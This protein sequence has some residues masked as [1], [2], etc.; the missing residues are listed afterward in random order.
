MAVEPVY[1]L[2]AHP[3]EILALFDEARSVLVDCDPALPRPRVLAFE[4]FESATHMLHGREGCELA[5]EAVT[6]ERQSDD[7]VTLADALACS[8]PASKGRPTSPEAGARR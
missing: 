2:H 3:N 5:E 6:L 7:P 8:R 4:G 1:G